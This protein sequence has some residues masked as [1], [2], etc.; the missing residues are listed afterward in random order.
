VK[1]L[2]TLALTAGLLTASGLAALFP[3]GTAT[4]NL[5]EEINIRASQD[6]DGSVLIEIN[7]DGWGPRW[8]KVGT[9]TLD[10]LTESGRFRYGSKRVRTYLLPEIA[11]PLPRGGGFR[12]EWVTFEYCEAC[13]RRDDGGYT[14]T[15]AMASCQEKH[16][17]DVSCDTGLSFKMG[18]ANSVSEAV[19]AGLFGLRVC[20]NPY[21]L[22]DLELPSG[23]LTLE[24]VK[25]EVAQALAALPTPRTIDDLQDPPSGTETFGP[26][27]AEAAYM[28]VQVWQRVSSPQTTYVI[29]QPDGGDWH[30]LRL[31]ETTRI[32]V[33]SETP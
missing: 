22:A 14:C 20:A 2:L 19:F 12:T 6:A 27:R 32:T 33:H 11:L 8:A 3:H 24:Q 10:E 26:Y 5:S 23:M 21:L 4:A 7:Q 16:V 29:V 31:N 30:F 9:I 1:A 15:S 17:V 18:F 13:H 28:E 25:E